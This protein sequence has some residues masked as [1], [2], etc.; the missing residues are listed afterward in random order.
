M[1]S[2]TFGAGGLLTLLG[3]SMVIATASPTA[4]I[5]A[6]FGLLLLGTALRLRRTPTARLWVIAAVMVGGLGLIAPIGNLARVIGANGMVMNAAT[7]ANLMMALI[8]GGY[9]LTLLF[10]RRRLRAQ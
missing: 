8:C 9:L 5:P 7:F 3:L 2:A 6:L 4:A 1:I 10:S